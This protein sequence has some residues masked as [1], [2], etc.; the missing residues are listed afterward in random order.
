MSDAWACILGHPVA[1]SLSPALHAAGFAALGISARYTARDVA[2]DGLAAAVQALRAP[3]CLGAN[4]TAPHKQAVISL[5]DDLAEEARMLGAVNTIVQRGGR[6]SG[7]NTDARGLESWFGQAELPVQGASVLV[8]G[9]G[10][11]ARSTVLALGRAGA[12]AIRVLNRTPQRAQTLATDLQPWLPSTILSAGALDQ[13]AQPPAVPVRLVVNATSLGHEGAAPDVHPGWYGADAVAIELAYNPPVSP[14]MR[15]A[16]QRGA[17]VENGLGMLVHQAVLSFQLWT[18]RTPDVALYENVVRA[19][20]ASQSTAQP[21]LAKG[22][23]A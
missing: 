18:G 1:H 17:R 9:A 7:D 11:A 22:D 21:V 14:F 12:R 13:A 20:L 23:P 19:A 15:Q 4:V 5:L 8:L 3:D 6:L 2:P 10:G 16:Q